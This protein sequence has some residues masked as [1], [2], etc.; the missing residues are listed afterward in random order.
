MA[1]NISAIIEL[2]PLYLQEQVPYYE[3]TL[4]PNIYAAIA[5]SLGLVYICVGLRIYGRH[6]QGLNLWWDD[7]TSII[8]LV[9][10]P[11]SKYELIAG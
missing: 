8:A 7:Y 11:C 6:L 1:A 5:V 9:R 2:L 10:Y 4:Q 3:E